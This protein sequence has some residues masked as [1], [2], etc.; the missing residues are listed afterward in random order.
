MC[1]PTVGELL[2]Q[3]RLAAGLT[4]EDLAERAR[5]SVRAIG[6]L[7]RG[8]RR[9]PHKATLRL[10]AEALSLGEDERARLFDALR[11]SRR[12]AAV[13]SPTA[14]SA[15]LP[16]GLLA[17]L[18]PLVGREREE[19]AIA[20]LLRREGVRLL[21]LTGP[22]GIGKTRRA[23]EA[24]VGL[25]ADFAMVVIVSLAAI[26]NPAL[27]LP[28]IGQALGLREQPNQSAA[29][30]LTEYLCEREALLVLDNFEQV[31]EA[32]PVLARLLAVCP[33]VKA[34]VTSRVTLCVRGEHE[35]AVSPLETPDMAHLPALED[36][37]RY[38]AVALFMQRIQAVKPAFTVTPALAPVIAAICAR[39]D[40][41]PLAL[42]LA[43]ARIKL[44]PP[45]ALLARLDG[46]LALLTNGAADLPERQQTSGAV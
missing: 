29:E 34:V 20:Q 21:A 7:E 30:R 9:T 28:A 36:L 40:G 25:G 14:S 32:G 6:A 23:T 2:R 12:G 19:A 33:R 18:T 41:I 16:R 43:A 37:T 17:P 4:Q 24:A 22:A 42:E 39:L 11:A 27:V 15:G 38:P 10:L 31:V 3:H 35:F 1:T 44:L 13:T 45:R 5:M 8:V 46:S 26:H